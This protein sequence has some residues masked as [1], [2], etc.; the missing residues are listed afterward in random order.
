MHVDH[1]GENSLPRP[2]R[3]SEASPTGGGTAAALP[4]APTGGRRSR[5]ATRIWTKADGF[6]LCGPRLITTPPSP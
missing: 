6:T 5:S 3:H 1:P 2:T 4:G